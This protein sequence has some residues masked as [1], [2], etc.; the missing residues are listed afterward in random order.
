MP[1]FQKLSCQFLSINDV[2][3]I[4][5]G[6]LILLTFLEIAFDHGF[7]QRMKRDDV[8]VFFMFVSIVLGLL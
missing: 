6:C 7:P 1:F 2:V 4:A 3:K 5:Y 8:I